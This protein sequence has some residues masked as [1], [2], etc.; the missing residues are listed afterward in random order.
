MRNK[1]NYNYTLNVDRL[2]Q[3]QAY[4][5]DSIKRNI[6]DFDWLIR[7]REYD[8]ASE[9][10]IHTIPHILARIEAGE[11][12][13]NLID[14]IPEDQWMNDNKIWLIQLSE[15]FSAVANKLAEKKK[16]Q[17]VY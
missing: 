7:M 3:Q 5:E 1:R 10:G 13:P 15:Y 16:D 14:F 8:S 12:F 4:E 2:G 9:L 11:D 6:D 17:V